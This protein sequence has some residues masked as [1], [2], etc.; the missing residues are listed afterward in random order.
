MHITRW[1]VLVPAVALSSACTGG[2][3]ARGRDPLEQDVA[4]A[5]LEQQD[6][7]AVPTWLAGAVVCQPLPA[8]S[9]PTEAQQ[10]R[11][12]RLL[13]LGKG[14]ALAGNA[15]GA[16]DLLRQAAYLDGTNP[17]VAYHLARASETAGD[18]AMAVREYCRYLSFGVSGAERAE[19]RERLL[20]LA[21]ARA[22]PA[23]SASAAVA[24]SHRLVRAAARRGSARP[25]TP[26]ERTV[27]AA[28][29]AAAPNGAPAAGPTDGARDGA[30]YDGRADGAVATSTDGVDGTGN[31]PAPAPR[32]EPA[33]HTARDAAIGA[34]IGAAAGAVV[35]RNVKGA[36]VG[37]A[38]G[39]LMGAVIGRSRGGAGQP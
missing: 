11:A 37:A 33:R 18:T 30:T 24:V 28:G 4:L 35:G 7:M 2:G 22:V 14:A 32:A 9:R 38:A 1:L 39:G 19:L 6:Q 26:R 31:R 8:S 15:R 20:L 17:A 21:P 3:G 34:V 10:A 13:E 12:A 16:Q 27:A 23:G 29:P 5:A 25:R 36:V